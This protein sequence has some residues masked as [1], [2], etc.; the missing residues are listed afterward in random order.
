MYNFEELSTLKYALCF[1]LSVNQH[2]SGFLLV[3][4]QALG[5]VLYVNH[6]QHVLCCT[7]S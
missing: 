6:D 3:N 1:N 2:A 4:Q 7:P 5:A